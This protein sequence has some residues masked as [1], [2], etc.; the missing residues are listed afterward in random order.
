MYDVMEFDGDC[1]C[2]PL[3]QALLKVPAGTPPQLS[4]FRSWQKADPG[5]SDVMVQAIVAQQ[6]AI[7][8]QEQAKAMRDVADCMV[9]IKELDVMGDTEKTRIVQDG[10]TERFRIMQD[11]QSTRFNRLA[12]VWDLSTKERAVTERSAA[13]E[14][15]E[16]TREAV[17]SMERVEV[18]RVQTQAQAYTQR[19][20]AIVAFAIGLVTS[21]FSGML[22]FRFAW[23]RRGRLPWLTMLLVLSGG[24]WATWHWRP[25]LLRPKYL[26][27]LALRKICRSTLHYS[28]G[29]SDADASSSGE[30]ELAQANVNIL[31][32]E[33]SLDTDSRSSMQAAS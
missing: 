24:S 22:P 25:N 4:R 16:T 14:K 6:H 33:A 32:G 13:K 15:A 19:Y 28:L 9:R 3:D 11:Q 7:V 18:L 30:I 1:K 10:L 2:D 12:K 20:L 31:D 23:R 27:A 5:G 26:L 17:A 29:S 8:A 21:G